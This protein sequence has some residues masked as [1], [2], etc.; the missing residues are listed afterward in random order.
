MN[1]GLFVKLMLAGVG[2]PLILL[3]SSI[4]EAPVRLTGW[5]LFI[6]AFAAVVGLV[7]ALFTK[8][9]WKPMMEAEI[10]KLPTRLEFDTHQADDNTFQD[11]AREFQNSTVEFRGRM[12]QFLDDYYAVNNRDKRQNARRKG[13][14]Q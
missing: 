12:N 2:I 13:D 5:F 14:P 6:A 3:Q 11:E 1:M 10:K 9:V 8:A 4:P 7:N